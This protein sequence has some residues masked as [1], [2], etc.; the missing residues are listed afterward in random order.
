MYLRRLLFLLLLVPAFAFRE[1]DSVN[2]GQTCCNSF[3]DSTLK[4]SYCLNPE[5]PAEYKGGHDSLRAQLN[6]LIRYPQKENA[7]FQ[8]TVW[9]SFIVETDGSISHVQLLKQVNHPYYNSEALRVVNQL[10][11]W[12]TAT[13]D[14]NKVPSLYYLPVR[15]FKV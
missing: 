9:L 12:Q 11:H 4:R 10:C 8:G 15:F 13:C 1:T 6:K 7:E 3:Y 5:I 14:G 2:G